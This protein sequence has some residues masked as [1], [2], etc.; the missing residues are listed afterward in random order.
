MKKFLILLLVMAFVCLMLAA[1]GEDDETT[2]TTGT[3]GSSND[4]V[5]GTTIIFNFEDIF[6]EGG[7]ELPEEEL[8]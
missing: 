6:G 8:D 5:T 2:G 4:S 3:S 1:C 7:Y